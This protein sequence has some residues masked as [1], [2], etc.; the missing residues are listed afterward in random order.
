MTAAPNQIQSSRATR[1]A[2]ECAVIAFW[3]AL[4]L[5]IFPIQADV[6]VIALRTHRYVEVAL[7]AVACFAIVFTPFC[8][9]Q[10]RLLREP[11]KWRGRGYQIA[12]GIILVLDILYIGQLCFFS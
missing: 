5:M 3:L 7:V 4:S 12:T 2:N 6:I 1:R 8:I 10:Y 9:A 11:G